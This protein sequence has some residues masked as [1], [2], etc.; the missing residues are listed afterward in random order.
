MNYK[1]KI[2]TFIKQLLSYKG[3]YNRTQFALNYFAIGVIY[4]ICLF[5]TTNFL[6]EFLSDISLI[7]MI[8]LVLAINVFGVLKRLR[9]LGRSLKY[10]F[11]LPVPIVNTVFVFYL[12]FFKGAK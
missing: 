8:I 2:L 12:I 11:L 1:N 9:D 5:I 10:C 3:T 7:A 6:N 4:F